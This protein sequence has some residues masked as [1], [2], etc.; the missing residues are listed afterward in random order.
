LTTGELRWRR[1]VC[2]AATAGH[3]TR[4]ELTHNLL[5]LAEGSLY[6]NTNLGSIARLRPHDGAIEWA[7]QYPRGAFPSNDPDRRDRHFFRDLTPCVFHQGMV[8]C[9]P[10]DSER[11]FALDAGSGQLV[12]TT[13]VEVASDAVHLIG[14][15]Q[16]HLVASGDYIYWLDAFTGR[17]AG[18]Y[19]PPQKDAPGYALPSPHGY[20]RGL[21]AGEHVYWPTRQRILVFAAPDNEN[22]QAEPARFIDLVERGARGGNLLQAG[23][24]LLISGATKMQAFEN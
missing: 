14:V 24:R 13:P 22:W 18:Q 9:A 7:V 23:D 4:D 5:T 17:L 20:G 16:N 1:W 6:Y 11:I 15:Q 21:L 10:C 19:P 12:W 2:S 8:L 3:G